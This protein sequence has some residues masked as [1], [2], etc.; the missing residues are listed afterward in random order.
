MNKFLTIYLSI[1]ESIE[2]TANQLIN[3]IFQPLYAIARGVITICE[4]W[5]IP[6]EENEEEQPENKPTIGFRR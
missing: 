3:L 4:I 2:A 1:V 5:N 6:Y